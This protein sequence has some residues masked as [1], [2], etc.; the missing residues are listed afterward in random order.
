MNAKDIGE[1]R[2]PLLRGS[3]P[4]LVRAAERARQEALRT[5]TRLVQVRDGKLVYVDPATMEVVEEVRRSG[6]K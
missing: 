4:A 3:M 1:A 6:T 5:G 2:D